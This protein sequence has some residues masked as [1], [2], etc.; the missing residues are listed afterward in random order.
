MDPLGAASVAVLGWIT[1]FPV[2]D[3]YLQPTKLKNHIEET[4]TERYVAKTA[5]SGHHSFTHLNIPEESREVS[6]RS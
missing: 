6:Y 3:M 2:L 1:P 4:Q 5:R